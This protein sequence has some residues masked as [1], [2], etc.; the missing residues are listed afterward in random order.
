LYKLVLKGKDST[1]NFEIE[2]KQTLL[3]SFR[4]YSIDFEAPCGGKGICGKCKIQILQGNDKKFHVEEINYFSKEELELGW[5]LSCLYEPENDILVNWE[6]TESQKFSFLEE[7]YAFYEEVSPSLM[8]MEYL[9]IGQPYGVAVDIGTTTVVASLFSFETGE[10][11]ENSFSINPQKNYGLDV[12]SR[13]EYQQNNPLAETNLK[14]SILNC[15]DDLI[16]KLSL[17]TKINRNQIGAITIAGNTAMLHFLLGYSAQC[18]GKAPYESKVVGATKIDFE[19]LGLKS[20]QN[21]NVYVLPP[22]KGFIGSDIS[23]G[24]LVSDIESKTDATLFI[25][26]GTNG[27]LVMKTKDK[28]VCCSCA[29]G[30]AFEGANISCGMRA[31]IGAIEKIE[32]LDTGK[33]KI[34]T[35]GNKKPVGI[36]GSG[37]MDLLGEIARVQLV[38][39]TGRLKKANLLEDAYKELVGE[40]DS[41]RYFNLKTDEKEFKI[42]QS[43]LRQIQLA[44]GA[45]RSGIEA[46]IQSSN[47]KEN[48]LNEVILAGQ[49]GKH[50]RV[51]SL[52]DVGII[53]KH[54][55]EKVKYVGNSSKTG[56][57]MCLTHEKWR[58]KIEKLVENIEYL[59]LSK[60]DGY[61]R[62]FA[63]CLKF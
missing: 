6:N 38:G 21:G 1:K 35:I 45:I 17:S 53:P 27:E 49:F 7:D 44:K 55:K 47:L 26:I 8:P 52:V 14:Q 11:V 57:E 4:D 48:E 18:L 12:L 39:K 29:A 15:I 56:A 22:I 16:I 25:D 37:I 9:T 33:I 42:Y 59:E 23:A 46:L 19:N 32:I 41:G 62:L 50:L 28:M 63:E 3:K 24:L 31:E 10:I 58:E 61:D 20:V 2:K 60:L 13:I 51:Q 43:D 30:P 34:E 54:L 36:C 40:D 5:R